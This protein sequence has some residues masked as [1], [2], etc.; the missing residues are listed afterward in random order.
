[1]NSKLLA[2]TSILVGAV[3]WLT[4]LAYG[5]AHSK[6]TGTHHPAATTTDAAGRTHVR[7]MG[8]ISDA[9]RRAAARH[10]RAVR[11]NFVKSIK[12]NGGQR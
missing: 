5:Q 3:L 6:P 4:P 7:P 12:K 1:M 11:D 8:R 10:R 9:Q 2:I